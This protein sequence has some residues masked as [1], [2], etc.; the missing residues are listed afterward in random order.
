[1]E[2]RREHQRLY[3]RH[4]GTDYSYQVM[5]GGRETAARLL[6]ISLGGARFSMREPLQYAE[7][8]DAGSVVGPSRAP[9]YAG[10]FREVGYTVAWCEGEQFG[11]VFDT[12]LQRDYTDL[13]FDFAPRL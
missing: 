6:D 5:V 11:V 4:Y 8:G 9:E 13:C 10:Y 7:P 12:P 2:E 3:L 1:M